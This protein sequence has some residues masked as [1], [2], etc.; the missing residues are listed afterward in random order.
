VRGYREMKQF[1]VWLAIKHAGFRLDLR[2][3]LASLEKTN[4]DDH[5]GH[6]QEDMD[7]PA[8]RVRRN[9]SEQ[10]QHQKYDSKSPE[11]DSAPFILFAY[12]QS[13][14]PLKIDTSPSKKPTQ[15]NPE[16]SG[17]KCAG[18]L[19]NGSFGFWPNYPLFSRPS[20]FD[21]LKTVYPF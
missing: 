9:D 21:I 1:Y 19:V 2:Q 12:Q 4:H 11:H 7:Q 3:G 13:G 8:G 10:P 18:L 15:P 5:Q 16:I 6:H 14:F 20:V 17:F